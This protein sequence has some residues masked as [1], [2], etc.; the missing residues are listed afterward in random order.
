MQVAASRMIASVGSTSFGSSRSSTWISPGSIITTPR[1][2]DL[3]FVWM[4]LALAGCRQH[5]AGW[6][7]TA[8]DG[9]SPNSAAGRLVPLI[10]Q[11][12]GQR[13]GVARERLDPGF[14]ACGDRLPVLDLDR[15]VLLSDGD[16]LR[17]PI[18]P[19]PP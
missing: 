4:V 10:P 3:P 19:L 11:F 15:D 8:L 2:G 9:G 18:P 13:A 1:T 16:A 17:L 14:V 12:V 5:S 7:L 6:P